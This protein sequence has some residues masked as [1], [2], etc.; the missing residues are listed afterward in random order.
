MSWSRGSC[1]G[2]LHLAENYQLP[3]FRL[4]LQLT[5]PFCTSMTASS[6]PQNAHSA[7]TLANSAGTSQGPLCPAVTHHVVHAVGVFPFRTHM[8]ETAMKMGYVAVKTLPG[9]S[10]FP[11]G[12]LVRGHIYH[13]SEILEVGPLG[14][15]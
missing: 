14:C 8:T 11:P 12:V 6:V 5:G 15:P 1:F 13:F 7:W 3:A 2:M 9:C 4:P 10:L